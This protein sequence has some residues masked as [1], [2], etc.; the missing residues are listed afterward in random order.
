MGDQ[1]LLLAAK[2]PTAAFV[3]FLGKQILVRVFHTGCASQTAF[4]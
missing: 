1:R 3:S 2:H 4:Y